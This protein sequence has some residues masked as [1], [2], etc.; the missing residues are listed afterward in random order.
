MLR[1]MGWDG[2]RV[3]RTPFRSLGLTVGAREGHD[4]EGP[5]H[6]EAAAACMKGVVVCV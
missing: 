1:C 3:P 5:V 4:G 2:C 6:E